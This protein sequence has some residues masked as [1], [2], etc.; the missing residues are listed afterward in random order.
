MLWRATDRAIQ[1]AMVAE[2]RHY[3]DAEQRLPDLVQRI[4]ANP[5]YR[6]ALTAQAR[7]HRARDYLITQADGYPPPPR[8]P[9]GFARRRIGDQPHHFALHAY[10]S[11]AGLTGLTS[12]IITG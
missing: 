6:D 9:A 5:A 11:F 2:Q 12:A 1:T 10:A 8:T 7:K 4:N 3:A